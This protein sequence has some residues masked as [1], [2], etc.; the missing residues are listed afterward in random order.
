M[1]GYADEQAAVIGGRVLDQDN[2]PKG[3][4][5]EGPLDPCAMVIFGASGDLTERKLMPALYN[6]FVNGGL[7]DPVAIIGCA[8]TELSHDRFR[9]K[10]RRGAARHS[11]HDLSRWP[12]FARKIFYHPVVY[13][14]PA[15][16]TELAGYLRDMDREHGTRGNRIFYLAT[17]PSLYESLAE[18]L[19][20]SGLS[21]ERQEGSGWVRI[22]VEKPFSFDLE[23]AVRLNQILL[24]GFREAQI[25]RMD[26]YMAKETVQNILMFRFANA[27]FEPVWDRRYVDLVSITAAET[28]G[29]EHRAGYYE[30]AGVLRDMFQN[31]MLQLLS[32]SAMESPSHFDAER[33]RD[34]KVKL[35]RS[36]RPFPVETLDD[37]LVLGQYGPGTINGR[38]VQGYRTEPGVHPAS[39]T[40]TFGMMKVLVDNWRWQGVPFFLTSGKRLPRKL[41]KMVIKF[42]RAPH[43]MFRHVLAEN[44]TA[45]QLTLGIQPEETIHLTFQTKNPGAIVCLRS[46]RM[47]FDYLQDYDGPV[48]DAYE[49]ALLDC[50]QGDHMLFWRQDGV[51]QTWAFMKP[52]IAA[53]EQCRDPGGRLRLYPAGTWG[54]EETKKLIAD[55][56]VWGA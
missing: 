36:L 47:E 35:F 21:A 43:S 1:P 23:S 26:H 50:I 3:C 24:K 37:H 22:V 44:I 27:I 48:L 52:V 39:V 14:S 42:K 15:S 32:M 33:V 11:P 30:Q 56:A 20:R 17:P 38:T 9:D 6:L 12:E 7:P 29:V 18:R 13:E 51:E 10:L 31:H 46:V 41:T 49:K 16:F 2:L 4:L 8:R 25:F 45:N 54:P 19:G 40:P 28:L 5:I 34:E 55:T 53:C